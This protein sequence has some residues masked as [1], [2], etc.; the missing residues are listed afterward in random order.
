MPIELYTGQPG[1]G[2]TALA[3]ERLLQAA[4]KADRPLYSAGID[5]LQPGLATVLDDITKWNDIDPNGEPVCDCDAVPGQRHAHVLPNGALCFVDE[6][7]KWFGHLQ[8]ATRQNTPQHVLALA[9]H[10]HRGIDF[11]WT[12]QQPNQ[13]YPFV[14]G[15]IADHHHVVRRFGT[16]FIDVYSWGELNEEIKSPAKREIALKKTR[17]LPEK[18][19]GKYKSASEH[20]IKAR[21]PW[22]V[23]ALPLIVLAAIAAGVLAVNM[24]R[25]EK[26]A[27]MASGAAPDAA[28]AAPLQAGAQAAHT[29]ADA[30]KFKDAADYARQHL[31]RIGA[32]PWSAPIFDD[33]GV[34]ADPLL[35]CMS[36]PGGKDANGEY[37][38]PSCTCLTEQGTAYDLSQP[39]CRTLARRGPV[40][41]PYRS[42]RSDPPQHMPV[43]D[44]RG[45]TGTARSMTAG[46]AMQVGYAENRRGDVFPRSP[47][48]SE[49]KAGLPTL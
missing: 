35:V 11:I 3:V 42:T 9:E 49:S 12:T 32:M 36:S 1:N 22:R 21:L 29:Q 23:I 45:R 6:A 19:F 33:R 43:Q 27:G 7:W 2:K 48:Y 16:K 28:S 37:R 10:R 24:L 25:P 41:N 14:R 18:S 47:G 40:Y 38:G 39:E 15:L 5:G 31:P 4:E 8:N 26:M 34:T 20:T 30:P 46:H 13:L 17:T 44:Q